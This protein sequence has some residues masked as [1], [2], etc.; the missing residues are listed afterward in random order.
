MNKFDKRSLILLHCCYS[1]NEGITSLHVLA[2]LLFRLRNKYDI[3]I[4]CICNNTINSIPTKIKLFNITVI[5]GSNSINEFSAWKEGYLKVNNIIMERDIVI[6]TNDTI[7]TNHPFKFCIDIALFRYLIL[8][9]NQKEN[10]IIGIKQN[11]GFKNV[12]DYISSFLVI[13]N[14][15]KAIELTLNNIENIDVNAELNF[16]NN[17]NKLVRSEDK[18]YELFLN[19]WLTKPSKKSW[20]KAEILT[21]ENNAKLLKKAQCILLEH[22]ISTR[23]KFEKINLLDLFSS[24]GL[25]FLRYFYILRKDLL[26]NKF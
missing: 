8:D 4:I 23:S 24:S 14:G 16:E 21:I 15:K 10:T 26:G 6:L 13:L 12:N 19:N 1:Q 25:A 9:H 22:S 18:D 2:D 7:L 20:H 3:K 17:E 11:L 5:Q